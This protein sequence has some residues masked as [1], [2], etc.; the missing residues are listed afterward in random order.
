[1]ESDILISTFYHWTLT[2]LNRDNFLS[3]VPPEFS[4]LQMPSCH[5]P[6]TVRPLL[7]LRSWRRWFINH[8]MDFLFVLSGLAGR[9]TQSFCKNRCKT[10]MFQK[11]HVQYYVYY[12]LQVMVLISCAARNLAPLFFPG[13]IHACTCEPCTDNLRSSHHVDS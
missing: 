5:S 11:T 8:L 3:K 4:R 2:E 1:M 13:E 12:R 6:S 9:V 7:W 10:H